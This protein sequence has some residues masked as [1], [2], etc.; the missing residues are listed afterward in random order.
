MKDLKHY[1]SLPYTVTI[2]KDE[3]GDFV[4]RVAEL[5]GCAAHGATRAEASNNIEDAIELWI[6][7]ALEN[8]EFIPEPTSET[9]PSGKW[10]QRVPRLLHRKLTDLAAREN[11]SL[12]QLVTAILA[13]AVGLRSRRL[14]LPPAHEERLLARPEDYMQL[15]AHHRKRHTLIA[16]AGPR[17]DVSHVSAGKGTRLNFVNARHL[18]VAMHV[19]LNTGKDFEIGNYVL[20][21]EDEKEKHRRGNI[22]RIPAEC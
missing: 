7:H 16:G 13:E 18:L 8:S 20:K 5:P 6:S 9:L 14:A 15:S 10:V 19:P 22:R 11:S 1:L 12:N 4:A 3:D 2:Q 21:E 17:W